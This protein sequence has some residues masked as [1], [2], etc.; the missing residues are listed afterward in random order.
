MKKTKQIKHLV[1]LA[2]IITATL[3]VSAIIIAFIAETIDNISLGPG[4]YGNADVSR[5][6]KALEYVSRKIGIDVTDGDL[7]FGFDDHGGF[8]GDGTTY[9]EI[10][11]TVP[12]DTVISENS[13]WQRF[14]APKMIELNVCKMGIDKHRGD[15]EDLIPE[16]N[17][18]WY[19]F[20]D[21]SPEYAGDFLNFTVAAY[22]SDSKVFYFCKHDA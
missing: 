7:Y 12:I 8:H 17:N 3:T 16:I 14:P 11:I 13:D 20:I 21:S 4:D 19:F 18:G 10:R 5:K 15:C 2:F 1:E 6:Q 22:D 9:L